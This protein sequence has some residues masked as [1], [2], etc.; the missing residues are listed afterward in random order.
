MAQEL[1]QRSGASTS[2]STTSTIMGDDLILGRGLE[3]P[4]MLKSSPSHNGTVL[5]LHLPL[6]FSVLPDFLKRLVVAY[7][8]AWLSF[9]QPEWRQRY[10]IS[11]GSFLYKFKNE[12]APAP[13]GS[14]ISMDK[15][16]AN[17]LVSVEDDEMAPAFAGLPPGYDSIFTVSTFGKKHY[18]AVTSRDEALAWVN[19]LRQNRQEAITRSM[20]HANNMPY[21]KNWAYFDSLGKSLQ[22]SK[23]RIKAKVEQ[24]NTR[25]MEMASVVG[26]GPRGYYG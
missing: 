1:R 3:A 2:T 23:Q 14:P 16:D 10:L 7:D 5:K 12:S 6:I 24:Y 13:K 20:G 21:P 26:G 25:E 4:A 18:Y 11:I 15:I 22:K 19:S 17:L 8:Y 9:L